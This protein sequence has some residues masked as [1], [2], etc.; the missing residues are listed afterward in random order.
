A[1]E[2]FDSVKNNGY[3]KYTIGGLPSDSTNTE[4]TVA[5]YG[6]ECTVPVFADWRCSLSD[7]HTYLPTFK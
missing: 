3:D 6:G 7:L 5:N 2:N 1:V 4:M